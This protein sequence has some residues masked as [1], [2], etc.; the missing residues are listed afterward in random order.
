MRFVWLCVDAQRFC[1][2]PQLRLALSAL[3]RL[4]RLLVSRVA[5]ISLFCDLLQSIHFLRVILT[6]IRLVFK[7]FLSS[8]LDWFLHM[9]ATN[10]NYVDEMV[11]LL[12]D[13]I[14]KTIR[15]TNQ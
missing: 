6:E 15:L 10:A 7:D 9:Q 14:E 4:G 1:S 2:F 12:Q 3:L 5:S 13:Q 11:A 8:F